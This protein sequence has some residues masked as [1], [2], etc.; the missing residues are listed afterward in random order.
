MS[1]RTSTRTTEKCPGCGGS[2]HQRS[3]SEMTREQA[4]CGTW[5]D[6]DAPHCHSSILYESEALK[7][8][9][10]EQSKRVDERNRAAASERA[11]K[12]AIAEAK[13]LRKLNRCTVTMYEYSGPNGKPLFGYWLLNR[14][15][16]TSYIERCRLQAVVYA[17]FVYR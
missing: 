14:D 8:E 17:E 1:S 3:D 11:V 2:M 6:C 9:L 7:A 10:A 4:W 5:Y 15:E 12:D 16:A 13:R